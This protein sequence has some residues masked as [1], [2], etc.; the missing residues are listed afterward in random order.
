MDRLEVT[1]YDTHG[2]WVDKRFRRST[3]QRRSRTALCGV[4]NEGQSWKEHADCRAG[5]LL[6]VADRYAYILVVE[7]LLIAIFLPKGRAV[8]MGMKEGV[9]PRRALRAYHRQGMLYTRRIR[10][11]LWDSAA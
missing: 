6:C 7:A 2:I 4:A 3:V 5:D 10:N 9:W 8:S 1:K 11:G